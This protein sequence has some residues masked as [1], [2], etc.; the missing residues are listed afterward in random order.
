MK[1]LPC[2]IGIGYASL[3]VLLKISKYFNSYAFDIKK[4]RIITLKKKIDTNN[5][6]KFQDFNKLKKITYTNKFNKI[7]SSSD[8]NL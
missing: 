4:I 7:K 8:L 6:F 5:E 2:L 1:I 3:L